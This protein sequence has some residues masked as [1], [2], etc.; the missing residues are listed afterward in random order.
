MAKVVYFST[1]PSHPG[2]RLNFARFETEKID[3]CIEFLKDLLQRHT[4]NTNRDQ[5]PVLYATG[6]GAHLFY[7]QLCKVLGVEV[8]RVDEMRALI[9]GCN[10]LLQE[11][12]Y[13]AFA[14]EESASDDNKDQNIKYKETPSNLFP[15]MLVNIGSGV[16]ILKVTGPDTFER[17][18]GT[19][20]GGGTLWGLLSLLTE[21][22][23]FDDI[24]KMST[25]GDNSKVDLLVGDIYG[26]DYSKIGLK[27]STIASSMG[28]VFRKGLGGEFKSEDIARSLLY[29]VSNNIG[30]ISYLNA[31]AHGLERIYFGG[32]F[33]RGHPITMAT[34]S[35]AIKFWSQGK[36][37]ALFLR[38]EGYLGSMGA[39]L[40][41]PGE[42][43][44]RTMH[45]HSFTENF[46]QAGKL[47]PSVPFAYG[48][49]DQEPTRLMALEQLWQPD[50]YN[51]DS[52]VLSDPGIRTYWIDALE[53]TLARMVEMATGP[54][55]E[56]G[57]R[58]EDAKTS[59]GEDAST[60]AHD[61]RELYRAHLRTLREEP[62][63]YG[64]L[65]P[66]KLLILREQCLK[67]LGFPDVFKG[68]KAKEVKMALD[69]LPKLLE[70][71]DALE[72]REGEAEL[73]RKLVR[74]IWAGNMF[75]WGSASTMEM[76][77]K[78]ELKFE[79]AA[80]HLHP[81]TR[82]VHMDSFLHRLFDPSKSPHHKAVIFVDNSGADVVQGIIPFARWLLSRGTQVILAA[83]LV[84]V[85][86]DVTVSC[87]VVGQHS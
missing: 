79:T 71:L 63:A 21:A 40:S 52:Y 33:I 19:S 56:Q 49:L 5:R 13:E 26:D 25:R 4:V 69:S 55:S 76:L 66:R 24:L 86:N 65:S 47:F 32:Y 70:S 2:G 34:L 12:P 17:I 60:R 82:L 35:Y 50:E 27:S 1:D 23:S 45:R 18:S 28:K 51:P 72:E 37:Q 53:R 15:Y 58:A 75:D 41:Q 42:A 83:N 73:V 48:T 68:Q 84:P 38:H 39:F 16:S 44:A 7:D 20:L 30:Q 80:D 43:I 9:Q 10:F 81:T 74:N 22:E 46:T 87:R 57:I 3:A 8:K 14:Y 36:V 67:E 61:F 64:T 78:E 29:M 85:I 62:S 54:G 59:D 6:G 31:Q 77:E 11:I